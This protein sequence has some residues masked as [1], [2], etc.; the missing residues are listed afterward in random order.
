MNLPADDTRGFYEGM[1]WDDITD[2]LSD[3]LIEEINTPNGENYPC[4]Y[5]R[6]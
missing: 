2:I 6:N 1:S 4:T 5:N 3:L